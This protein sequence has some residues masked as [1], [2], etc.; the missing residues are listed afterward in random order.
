MTVTTNKRVPKEDI[1]GV[2]LLDKPVGPTSNHA[3]QVA[4]RL[5][6][7]KKAGH[8]GTLDPMAS[9]LLPLCFGEATKFSSF[10]LEA[11]KQYLATLLLGTVTTTGDSEGDIVSEKPLPS[12]SEEEIMAVLSGFLGTIE[13]V[14]PMYSALKHQGKPL[15]EYARQ[16]ITVERKSRQVSIYQLA[17]LKVDS[18]CLT[19]RVACSKG[20]YIRTLAC[21]IGEKLGVGAHLIALRREKTAAW[22]L[23]DAI[24]LEDLSCAKDPANYLLPVDSLVSHFP[25]LFLTDHQA[26]SLY[27]GQTLHDLSECMPGYYRLY[28]DEEK[29]RFLGLGQSHEDKTLQSVRLLR[30]LAE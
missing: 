2:L 26:K 25:A 5:F 1:D 17:C 9:G 28:V 7:A 11:D 10:A 13:Q 8:T 24:T 29:P 27:L 20:T 23:D 30:S 4:K 22:S 16:G 3:L 6:R 19:I 21:D 12:F 18:P 14:P 15:Y